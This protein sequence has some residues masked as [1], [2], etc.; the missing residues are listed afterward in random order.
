MDGRSVLA[1]R[2]PQVP[3]RAE[4]LDLATGRRAPVRTLGGSEMTGAVRIGNFAMTDDEKTPIPTVTRSPTSFSS[5][6]RDEKSL[7]TVKSEL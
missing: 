1:F 2:G 5:K 7:W 6:E 4:R 3:V